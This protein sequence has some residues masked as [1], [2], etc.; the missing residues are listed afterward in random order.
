P[1]PHGRRRPRAVDR[2]LPHPED[3][4]DLAAAGRPWEPS[5]GRAR[6]RPRAPSRRPD[7]LRAP[8]PAPRLVRVARRGSA[9][10]PLLRDVPLGRVSAPRP[11]RTRR[12]A[13]ARSRAGRPDALLLLLQA[14]PAGSRP[15]ARASRAPVRARRRRLARKARERAVGPALQLAEP[16]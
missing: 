7:A 14:A 9:G 2:R 5:A 8:R 3:R 10:A 4:R 15:A 1:L 16:G 11:R 12:R 6:A 13:R